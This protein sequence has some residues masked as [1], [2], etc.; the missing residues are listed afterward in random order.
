MEDKKTIK[1]KLAVP[2]SDE[3]QRVVNEGIVETP[4]DV[5]FAM[6]MGTGYAPFT[7]GPIKSNKILK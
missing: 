4:D 1:I 7:G 2:L 6:I 3:A 5:D